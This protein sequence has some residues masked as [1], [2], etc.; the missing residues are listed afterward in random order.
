LSGDVSVGYT[1]DFGNE[2]SSDHSWTLGGDANLNG[3]FYKPSFLSYNASL[4]LNR[5]QANSGFQSISDASGVN[6]AASLFGGS[7]FPGSI[8]YSKAYNSE[9]NF[10]VPGLS[11]YVTRGNSDA[12]GINWSEN[13]PDAP[14][15]SAGFVMGSNQYSIYGTSEHGESKFHSLNFHS[16]YSYA[17]FGMGAYYTTGGGDSLVPQL[18]TGE[19]AEQTHTGDSG[20]G[21]NVSHRLPWQGSLSSSLNRSEYSANYLGFRSSGAIDLFNTAA[22][23]HPTAKLSLSA[24]VDYSDNLSGQLYEAIV[25][26]GGTIP[27]SNTNASSDSLDMMAAAG[28]TPGHNVQ[29]SLYVERRSQSFEGQTYGDKTFGGSASYSHAF[30]NGFLSSS[31]N[32]NGNIADQTG[33]EIVGFATM[34][35]YSTRLLGWQVN[36]TFNY[37]QNAQTLL[38]TYMNSIYSFSGNA[39]RRWGK[40]ILNGGAAGSRTG[41]TAQ[42]GT[43]SDNQ[44][45]HAGFGYAGLLAA[46]G[47]YFRSNGQALETGGGLVPIPVP[48]PSNLISLYGGHGY[49][50][51][52]SGSP[53][54]RISIA[55]AYSNSDSNTS[56]NGATSANLSNQFNAYTQT[57]FR[58]LYFNSGY[59]RLYQSFSGSGAKP[60]IVSSFYVGISR[61]FNFF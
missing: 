58:K 11:N 37:S 4:Y 12:L 32:V 10:A 27:G 19:A 13:L 35:N 57:Q 39:R 52:L 16:G 34:E 42:S 30:R 47:S 44:D 17:G 8:S 21:F 14:S 49:S 36:G 28:Y 2:V 9:G 59:T 25:G 51:S 41:L 33:Q 31:L 26:A 50:L 61:W 53:F 48:V 7:K 45:Y 6:L 18:T 40:V 3:S 20:Y 1:A 15:F 55:A 54:K 38:V 43:I 60:E 24:N 46:S 56:S 29:T 23:M 22:Y 5:S